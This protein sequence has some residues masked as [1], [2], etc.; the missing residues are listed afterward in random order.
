M[1]LTFQSYNVH[2]EHY[3]LVFGH[4]L[5]LAVGLK[6]W[7]D[8]TGGANQDF[9]IGRG[10]NG[11]YVLRRKHANLRWLRIK[12]TLGK[13]SILLDLGD[14]LYLYWCWKMRRGVVEM[15]GLARFHHLGN[16]YNLKW[17]QNKVTRWLQ[18]VG[19]WIWPHMNSKFRILSFDFGH[20]WSYIFEY[21]L[22]M[23]TT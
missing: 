7:T 14:Q 9:A 19:L 13:L 23:Q 22:V 18:S 2:R 3:V 11:G 15:Y 5:A 17:D 10:H 4:S 20:S 21:E 16:V 1:P 12:E 8:C 6:Q